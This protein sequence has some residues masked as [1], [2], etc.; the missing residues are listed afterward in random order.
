MPITTPSN[1]GAVL[2]I[3]SYY[4]DIHNYLIFSC[5]F[6]LKKN[7][8]SKI[9]CWGIICIHLE[10]GVMILGETFLNLAQSKGFSTEHMYCRC[11]L[12]HAS[13]GVRDMES[14]IIAKF[15][16]IYFIILNL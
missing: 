16:M 5:I 3:F 15:S 10:M 14:S 12:K 4:I 2:V 6:T 13:M 9:S 1:Y 8:T 7:Q 11:L